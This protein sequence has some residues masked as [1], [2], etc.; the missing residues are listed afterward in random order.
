MMP[1][2]MKARTKVLIAMK[3]SYG[4]QAAAAAKIVVY[5][6]KSLSARAVSLHFV[7]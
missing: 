4:Y 3:M 1:I 2:I 6:K 7:E 5:C